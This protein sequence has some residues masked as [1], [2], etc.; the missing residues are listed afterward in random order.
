MTKKLL[1]VVLGCLMLCSSQAAVVIIKVSQF[2]NTTT[3]DDS[4]LFLV[5]KTGN[6]NENITTADLR[7]EMAKGFSFTTFVYT[8]NYYF[9]ATN[10]FRGNTTIENYYTTNVV[11][12]NYMSNFV[13]TNIY[14]ISTNINLTNLTITNLYAGDT[15]V[16]NFFN[17]NIF[18]NN[19]IVSNFFTTNLFSTTQLITTNFFN[20]VTNVSLAYITNLFVTQL[21]SNYFVFNTNIFNSNTYI[22]NYFNTNV[23]NNSYVSNFFNTN[24]F[25]T[26]IAISYITVTNYYAPDT[27]VSNFFNTNIFVTD[28]FVSNYFVT[29]LFQTIA[30]SSNFTYNITWPMTNATLYGTTTFSPVSGIVPGRILLSSSGVDTISLVASNG[31]IASTINNVQHIFAGDAIVTNGTFFMPHIWA[32]PTNPLPLFY[33]RQ[34]YTT[35]T[36]VSITGYSGKSNNVT[37]QLLITITNAATTNVLATLCAG[38]MTGNWTNQYT[39]SN[40]STAKIWF[41]YDPVSNDTNAVFRQMK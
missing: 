9:F 1:G 41:E 14:I 39:I 38:T 23:F 33:A 11:N 5:A 29:N 36:P 24:V 19:S 37:E 20:T 21:T 34:Y 7:T 4:D 22:S 6:T 31:A 35:W 16:S 17:T 12:N 13:N 30:I 40:A 32:G 26:N 18:V 25:S 8:T 3:L 2:P 15:F 27:F 28:N 10:L